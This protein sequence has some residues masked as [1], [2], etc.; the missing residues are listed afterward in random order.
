MLGLGWEW[1]V[2]TNTLAFRDIVL[3]KIYSS[4]NR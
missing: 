3:I 2:T 1:V 4:D